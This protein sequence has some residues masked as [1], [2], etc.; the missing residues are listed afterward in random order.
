MGIG[1]ASRSL[2]LPRAQL[3]RGPGPR[4]QEIT[5]V[6]GGTVMKHMIWGILFMT[7]CHAL[8]DE[9]F[10]PGALGR[11]FREA[12]SL[13]DTQMHQAAP[14]LEEQATRLQGIAEQY[15]DETLAQLPQAE[16]ELKAAQEHLD[17]ALSGVLDPAN[18]DKLQAL[19]DQMG[20]ELR[21]Q[22]LGGMAGDM[23]ETLKATGEQAK[24]LQPLVSSQT[25]ELGK[26]FSSAWETGGLEALPDLQKELEAHQKTFD[27]GLA[28]ILTPDQMSAFQKKRGELLQQFEGELGE[29]DVSQILEQLG[30]LGQNRDQVAAILE[31]GFKDKADQLNAAH[32]DFK[33]Q[34]ELLG[35]DFADVDEEVRGQIQ[36]V[37]GDEAAQKVGQIQAEGR[38][39]LRSR[40][41]AL[42][43]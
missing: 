43:R 9:P 28:G 33:K 40:L 25:E 5:S 15:R 35:S 38:R 31:G 41:G 7:T 4:Q 30:D 20:E 23:M 26:L 11:R 27:K 6:N 19:H 39:A 2:L 14:A 1:S 13:S 42:A 17:K 32:A 12:A 37:L 36:G 3:L 21:S 10:E 16:Q 34:A 18:R 8:A 24:E 22:L 29:H